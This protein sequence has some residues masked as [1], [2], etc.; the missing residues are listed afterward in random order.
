[1]VIVRSN[2]TI[3]FILIRLRLNGLSQFTYHLLGQ[4]THPIVYNSTYLKSEKSIKHKSA[5]FC[6]LAVISSF[7]VICDNV[8]I[9]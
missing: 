4:S 2:G 9:E 1:M 5:C 7:F 3:T 8:K 6:N